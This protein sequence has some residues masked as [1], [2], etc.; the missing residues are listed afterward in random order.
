[1]CIRDRI[2]GAAV[3]EEEAALTREFLN[4][5]YPPFEIPDEVYTHFR[6][7]IEKGENLEKEWNY[8]FEE[9]QKKI[10]F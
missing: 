5:E 1:M 9:Y 2:H 3:G 10:S 7:T 4:W 8:S 6:K